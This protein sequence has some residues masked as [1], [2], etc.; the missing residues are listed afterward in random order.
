[1]KGR[2]NKWLDFVDRTAWTFIV[3]FAGAIIVSGFDGWKEALGIAGLAALGTGAKVGVAQNVGDSGL[4][5]AIPGR[6][7][8]E[9]SSS[10]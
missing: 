4:G 10:Q 3:A 6:S 9:D 7:V 2:I 5:D 8:V 1:M